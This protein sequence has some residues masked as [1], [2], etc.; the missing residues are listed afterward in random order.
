MRAGETGFELQ[1][2]DVGDRPPAEAGRYRPG[3]L[4]QAR[5]AWIREMSCDGIPGDAE[6]VRHLVQVAD[7]TRLDGDIDLALNLLLGGA[8]R[9][10]WADPGEPAREL[11]VAAAE[12][13]GAAECDPRLL[14][15]IALAPPISPGGGPH[16]PPTPGG[17]QRCALS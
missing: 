1:G 11:V 7:Q 14:A 3:R 10:W 2:K 16:R 8:V 6:R 15:I 12:R 13:A 9:Y 5:I 17:A 4:Q